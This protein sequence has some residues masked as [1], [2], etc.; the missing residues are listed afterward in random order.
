M[1]RQ[2]LKRRILFAI[3]M[4]SMA[5]GFRIPDCTHNPA[6]ERKTFFFPS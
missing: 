5:L 4:A 2:I 6:R 3:L 1:L